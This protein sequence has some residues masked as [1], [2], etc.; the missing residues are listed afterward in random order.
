[1]QKPESCNIRNVKIIILLFHLQTGT[2]LT[3]P[4]TPLNFEQF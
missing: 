3:F 4:I 2:F 1:M